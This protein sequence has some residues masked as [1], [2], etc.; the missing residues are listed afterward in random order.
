MMANRRE[1]ARRISKKTGY[2]VQDILTILESEDECILDLLSEG[3]TKIKHHKLY[4]LEVKTRPKKRAY[5]GFNK[6]HFDLPE[7]KYIDFKPLIDLENKI[8]E[9]NE[10]S[11]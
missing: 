2:Y 4:Q 3:Y 1:I 10:E 9:I 6:T 5:D 7:R 8:L 11:E